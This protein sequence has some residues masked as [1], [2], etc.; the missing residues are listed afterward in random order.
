MNGKAF[1]ILN[2]RYK[3]EISRSLTGSDVQTFLEGKTN[4]RKEKPKVTY[5]M[6]LV[7]AFLVAENE[8]R[9]LEDF[10]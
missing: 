6:T 7:M 8:N 10:P 4:I 1:K 9:Q 5:S 2:T 3:S